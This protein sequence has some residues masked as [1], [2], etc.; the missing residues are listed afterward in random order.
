VLEAL[1][2]AGA[3]LEDRLEGVGV[4]VAA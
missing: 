2:N 1:K 3:D 4:E